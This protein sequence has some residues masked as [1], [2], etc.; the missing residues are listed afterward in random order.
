MNACT[1]LR[2]TVQ[3]VCRVLFEVNAQRIAL[4]PANQ[5]KRISEARKSEWIRSNAVYAYF[6]VV[7]WIPLWMKM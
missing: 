4:M 1:K 3:N 7:F 2:L 5:L 6:K